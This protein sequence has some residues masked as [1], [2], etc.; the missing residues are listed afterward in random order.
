MTIELPP[1]QSKNVK[2]LVASGAF[3]S[4]VEAVVQ[5]LRLLQAVEAGAAQVRGGNVRP[6]DAAAVRR[7]KARGRKLLAAEQRNRKSASR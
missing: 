4:P 1:A 7:I 6:F 2:Q 5:A 3:A